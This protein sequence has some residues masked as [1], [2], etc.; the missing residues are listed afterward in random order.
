[1]IRS[2]DSLMVIVDIKDEKLAKRAKSRLVEYM[3]ILKKNVLNDHQ[4]SLTASPYSNL[5][6]SADDNATSLP[7]LYRNYPLPASAFIYD[8]VNSTIN[9]NIGDVETYL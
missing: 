8:I 6:I 3:G 9:K 4:V 7:E 5:S 1:M 2:I